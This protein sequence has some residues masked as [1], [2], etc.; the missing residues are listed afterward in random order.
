MK[1][2]FDACSVCLRC[3]MDLIVES[4]LVL[5]RG[6]SFKLI[7]KFGRSDQIWPV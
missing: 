1:V 5:L 2:L 3:Y 7:I 4:K 6:T